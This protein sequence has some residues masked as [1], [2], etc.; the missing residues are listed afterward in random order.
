MILLFIMGYELITSAL[1]L[2]IYI[3]VE[4]ALGQDASGRE[5]SDWVFLISATLAA[6]FVSLSLTFSLASYVAQAFA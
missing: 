5:A 1:L 2:T 3:G 4:K 6:Y